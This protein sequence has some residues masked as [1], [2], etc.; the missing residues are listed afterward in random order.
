MAKIHLNTQHVQRRRNEFEHF[1]TLLFDLMNLL[2]EPITA[3]SEVKEKAIETQY[4]EV[5][6]YFVKIQ[7]QND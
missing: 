3:R 6:K 1:T 2:N 7:T 5:L 4:E